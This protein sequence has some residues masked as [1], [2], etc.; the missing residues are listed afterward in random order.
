MYKIRIHTQ[1]KIRFV[2]LA[3]S[4]HIGQ[5]RAAHE[6]QIHVRAPHGTVQQGIDVLQRSFELTVT[7]K[8]R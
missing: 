8:K 5:G 6:P 3:I 1:K 7:A 2:Y 4:S